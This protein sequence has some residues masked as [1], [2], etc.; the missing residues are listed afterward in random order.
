MLAS[1]ASTGPCPSLRPLPRVALA[2]RRLHLGFVDQNS[3][4]G[5]PTPAGRRALT[6]V[7]PWRTARPR[8]RTTGSSSPASRPTC[9]APPQL[10]DQPVAARLQE[11]LSARQLSRR[12]HHGRRPTRATATEI[13][14][15]LE[16]YLATNLRPR[17][18]PPPARPATSPP[19][20]YRVPD[21]RPADLRD[22]PDRGPS[23]STS[24]PTPPPTEL[25]PEGPLYWRVQAIDA[26]DNRLGWP[27]YRTVVKT[28]PRPP[29]SRR[30]HRA[31]ARA[32]G[33]AARSRSAGSE[34]FSATA[35]SSRSPPT[36]TQL[37]RGQPEGQTGSSKR[38]AYT[39]GLTAARRVT[40][41]ASNRPYVWRVR[42]VDP[43]QPGSV[44]RAAAVQGR[45]LANRPCRLP[46]KGPSG[47]RNLV[48][49]WVP[50]TEAAKY[51]LEYRRS[52]GRRP[53]LATTPPPR[54]PRR[55]PS[56]PARPTS[57]ACPR[58]MPTTVS[59]RRTPG[60]RSRSAACPRRRSTASI[61]GSGIFQP[62]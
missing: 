37:L 48:M 8:R 31:A 19:S 38:P 27:P 57:G 61:Q 34:A 33:P 45:L 39:T 28:S 22:S 54:S 11:G 7:K 46:P 1:P 4:R 41:Q 32:R 53:P 15:D 10:D 14:F 29:S 50:V 40:L 30:W 59:L 60:A 9:A 5:P 24:R 55:P 17:R 23:G 3:R 51:R 20:H 36:P 18:S 42:R 12:A 49:R 25:Y 44:V 2:R 43:R 62:P 52:A 6:Y 47:T 13:T 56:R 16:D 58:S 26:A 21:R 35:T